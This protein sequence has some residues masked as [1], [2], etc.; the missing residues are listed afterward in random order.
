METFCTPTKSA[1]NTLR[2]QPLPG[3]RKVNLIKCC[4]FSPP[5]CP[6]GGSRWFT[7]TATVRTKVEVSDPETAFQATIGIS[8]Q[9]SG[10][11]E[12]SE[13]HTQSPEKNNHWLKEMIHKNMNE[14][15][16]N[17]PAHLRTINESQ[18]RRLLSVCLCQ[19]LPP[20]VSLILPQSFSISLSLGLSV[21]VCQSLSLSV[22]LSLPLSVSISPYPQHLLILSFCLSF[23]P[24][25]NPYCSLS[26]SLCLHFFFLSIFLSLLIPLSLMRWVLV[27]SLGGWRWG[28]GWHELVGRTD[29][30]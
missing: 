13:R 23:P 30:G 14:L 27:C 5:S 29:L 16:L 18:L 2:P 9:Q 22:C 11:T 24:S 1:P 10:R 4:S 3:D 25:P 26:F 20:S 28:C 21:C 17:Q 7:W 19:C 12:L 6:W 8:E 15:L